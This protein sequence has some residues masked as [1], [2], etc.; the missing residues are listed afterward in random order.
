MQ[1]T[2]EDDDEEDL[3]GIKPLL[4]YGAALGLLTLFG[5]FY[6][7]SMFGAFGANGWTIC[8]TC[9]ASDMLQTLGSRRI[10]AQKGQSIYVDYAIEGQE[11]ALL[12]EL[13]LDG[14]DK[15][16]LHPMTSTKNY[17]AERNPES[18]RWL[19]KTPR[20]GQIRFQVQR[21]GIYYLSTKTVMPTGSGKMTNTIH[22]TATLPYSASWWAE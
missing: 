12:A 5:I 4:G 15:H 10:Y 21:S 17:W 11:G 16:L 9:P 22:T 14:L 1:W 18:K 7:G 6:I 2:I 19:V 3:S 13:R 8:S 20:K